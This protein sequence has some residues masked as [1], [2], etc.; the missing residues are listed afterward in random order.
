MKQILFLILTA[1]VL[2]KTKAQFPDYYVY[3]VKGNVSTSKNN[4]R[5]LKQGDF[6]FLKDTIFINKNSEIT[7]VNKESEYVVLNTQGMVKA[8]ALSNKFNQ[9]YSGV[10]KKYLSLVWEEVLDPNYDLSKFKKKNLTKSWG[11]VFRSDD[12][13]NLIFPVNG[14]KTS[15]DSINFSWH[16]TSETGNY[17]FFIYDGNGKEIVN[18]QVK[19]TQVVISLNQFNLSKGKYYWLEKGDSSSC[20]DEVP[21]YFQLMSKEDEHALISTIVPLT[22]NEN[23]TDG[24]QALEKLEK[25]A[26][27]YAVKSGYKNLINQ[28]PDN[29]TLT[30]LYVLFLL[31]YGFDKEAALAWK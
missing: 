7:I 26:L 5:V 15:Q 14:L 12:C 30:Q 3:L 20:E 31:K 6:I 22:Q 25:N 19:D 23:L 10:T 13:N 27:I 17:N 1:F 18:N 4:P 24:L 11:G 2:N 9:T 28:Y 16:A 8:N 21:L 29:K